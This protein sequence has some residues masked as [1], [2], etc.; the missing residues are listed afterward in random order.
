M[1]EATSTSVMVPDP[2]EV[3][4]TGEYDSNRFG[5]RNNLAGDDKCTKRVWAYASNCKLR[6]DLQDQRKAWVTGDGASSPSKLDTLDRMWRVALRKDTSSAQYQDSLS[7]VTSDIFY[8]A[9]RTI[10]AALNTIFFGD[11]E[12]PAEYEPELNTDEYDARVGQDIAHQRQLMEVFT[13]DEDDRRAKIKR[14][15]KFLERDCNQMVSIE[16]DFAEREVVSRVPDKFDEEGLPTRYKWDKVKRTVRDWPTFL[17]YRPDDCWFDCQIDDMDKQRLFLI[18][19]KV[20]YED[21][22]AQQA[23]GIYMNVEKIK[24]NHFYQGQTDNELLKDQS[25]NAEDHITP[26]ADGLVEVWHV[27]GWLPIKEK[28]YNNKPT[29]KGDYDSKHMS[30][31]YW[32]TFAGRPNECSVCLRLEKDP[33]WMILGGSNYKF[34]HSE[35]DS[36]G[37]FHDGAG[38]RGISLYG[39]AC[40]NMNQAI[41]NK[42]ERNNAPYIVDGKIMGSLKTWRKNNCIKVGKGVNFNRFQPPDT[43]QITMQ[44]QDYIES[45]FKKLVGADKPLTAEAL[46]SRTSATES[47]NV[48]DMAMMPLDEKAAYI[49][50]DQLFPWMFRVDALLWEYWADPKTVLQVTHNNMVHEVIPSR[51]WGPV[52]TKVVAVSRFRNSI[53]RRQELNSLL[54]GTYQFAEKYMG[55]NG[56]QLVWR[57]VYGNVMDNVDEIF[58]N[59]YDYEAI[60]SAKRALVSLATGKWIEPVAEEN[61]RAWLGVLEPYLEELKYFTDEDFAAMNPDGPDR[62]E[63]M[64][65]LNQHI[66]IRRRFMNEDQQRLQAPEQ[67]PQQPEALGLPGE[68]AGDLIEAEE[69]ALA[70]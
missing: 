33:Y 4:K 39:E 24:P 46:G 2:K 12:M 35:D 58:P 17:D 25:D 30:G 48:F 31:Y 49:G 69:G 15:I 41:D 22:V 57:Q 42:T 70:Q 23:Q 3:P 7:N 68:V 37:A 44:M 61:H 65:A 13:F 51:L 16:W 20:P 67:T 14:A 1:E 11:K 21:L 66:A 64:R 19:S 18:R 52:R 53:V 43:T 50:E 60:S 40:T 29:G 54:Q 38:T 36:N 63:V 10:S 59:T 47:K 32:G 28:S 62:Q 8:D 45:S 55:Q 5:E 9:C 34:L 6:Y 27:K 56:P 26:D